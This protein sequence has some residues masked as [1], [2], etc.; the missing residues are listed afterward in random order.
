MN[1]AKYQ[2][3]KNIVGL[4]RRKFSFFIFVAL[5]V[6]LGVLYIGYNRY[7]ADQ[8]TDVAVLSSMESSSTQIN[9]EISKEGQ[10][11]IDGQD[12][13]KRV[14]EFEGFDELRIPIVDKPNQRIETLKII[15]TLPDQSAHQTDH[16][17]LAIHGVTSSY[18]NILDSSTIEYVAT[19]VSKV[20][21]V[22]VVAK[23][24]Q[25]VIK[26]SILSSAAAQINNLSF[27][28]WLVLAFVLPA[29][30]VIYLIVTIIRKIRLQKVI[31]PQQMSSSPPMAIPPA[32][33]GVLYS[34]QVGSREVAAT[35]ID[36]ARRRDITIL[37]RDRGFS[38]AKGKFDKRL[39]GYE[40][41]LLSKIFRKDLSA[42]RVEIEK[43]IANRLYS[44]KMSVVS[45]SIYT[46]ATHLGYFSQNPRKVYAKY[47]YV[48]SI[49]FLVGTGGFF[50]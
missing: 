20:A 13:G 40:K 14:K 4:Y 30:T 28:F 34:S 19:G 44:K 39:L 49:A 31:M 46:I 35:L 3:K 45:A 43:R 10:I 24:P 36:L 11:F 47:L 33:V 32:V 16:Q 9:I 15:L 21:T 41:I 37:D 22:S 27:N 8:I 38:F 1:K 12:S 26:R 17:I 50:R 23:I 18:S 6:A 29:A 2:S 48:G 42:E 25:G 7:Q 5:L